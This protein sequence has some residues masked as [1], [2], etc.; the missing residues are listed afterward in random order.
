MTLVVALK[1]RD[2]IVME[3]DSKAIGN[4]AGGTINYSIQK[5]FRVG[6]D[7]LFGA[8]GTIGMIQKSLEIIRGFSE[9]LDVG[10]SQDIRDEIR[11]RLLTLAVRSTEIQKVYSGKPDGA[12]LADILLC[13]KDETKTHRIWHIAKDAVDEM[14]DVVGYGAVGAGDVFAHA[15]LRAFPISN[16]NLSSSKLLV[17][18]A[19]KGA[20]ATS[21]YGVGDPIDVWTIADRKIQREGLNGVARLESLY[22]QLL[23]MDIKNLNRTSKLLRVDAHESGRVRK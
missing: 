2:G 22:A 23:R 19:I 17:Y 1:C 6:N 4:S 8:S 10:T 21:A 12:P 11:D 16:L 13:T 14:I 15:I 9:K 18:K 20:I 3:S 5:I 7:S